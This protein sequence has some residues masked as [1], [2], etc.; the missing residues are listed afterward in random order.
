MALDTARDDA[1][2]AAMAASPPSPLF[3]SVYTG[4]ILPTASTKI[5]SPP[6]M[7]PSPSQLSRETL[8]AAGHGPCG[9]G[10]KS[11]QKAGLS[12]RGST[13]GSRAGA[14]HQG[15]RGGV[16]APLAG[17]RWSQPARQPLPAPP[18]QPRAPHGAQAEVG[19]A[20]GGGRPSQTNAT[21]ASIALVRKSLAWI[22]GIVP[23]VS[24]D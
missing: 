19:A 17:Q 5:K 2:L 1:L 13:R 12:S 22:T 24:T 4:Q 6:P 9:W 7:R 8:I 3:L 20:R 10:L 21:I 23:L 15:A 11:Q 18:P 14:A 16:A